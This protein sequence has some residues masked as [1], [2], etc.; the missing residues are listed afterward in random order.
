MSAP[1]VSNTQL[2]SAFYVATFNRAPD[3]SG[4]AFWQAQ[5]PPS[6]STTSAAA[7][8]AAGF[9]ANPVFT[10]NYG[11]DT[12]LQ[13]VNA[14][15]QNVLGGPGDA[16]GVAYW[17]TQLSS[18]QTKTQVLAAF[19]QGALT[20]DLSPTGAFAAALSAGDLAA[21]QA[22]QAFLTNKVNVGLV[23]AQT[24]GTSSNVA[25]TATTAAAIAAD[26]A[27]LASVAILQSVTNDQATAQAAIALI[28]T[29]AGNAAPVAYINTNAPAAVVAGQSFALTVGQD[30]GAAFTGGTGNDVFYAPL[31]SSVIS[32]PQLQT[33]NNSD[34]L[35]GG[36]G[37]NTLNASLNTDLTAPTLKNIQIVNATSEVP[38]SILDLLNATGVTTVAV[39][40][41]TATGGFA[42]VGAATKLSVTQQNSNASFSGST[43]TTINLNLDTVGGKA[44]GPVGHI[45]V[46]LAAGVANV[47]GALAITANN[48]YVNLA[49]TTS[50]A[51]VLSASV[52]AT[53]TNQL[54]F[55]GNDSASIKSLTVTGGGSLDLSASP[56]SAL[57]SV[58]AG[59]GSLKLVSTNAVAGALSITAGAGNDTFTVQGASVKSITTGNGND[60][61]TTTGNGNDAAVLAKQVTVATDQGIVNTDQGLVNAD[62]TIITTQNANI[63]AANTGIASIT[64]VV[65][66]DNATLATDQAT[67]TAATT[68]VTNDQTTVTNDTATRNA[69]QTADTNAINALNT[70]NTNLTNAQ[71]TLATDQATVVA[72]TATKAADQAT[73]NTTAAVVTNLTTM[74]TAIAAAATQAA[75]DLATATAVSQGAITDLQRATINAAFATGLVANA[76]T[77]QADA[78][79]VYTPIVNTANAADA[80]ATTALNNATNAL[81]AANAA[82][83]A[84]NAAIV[85]DNAAVAVATATKNAADTTLANAQTALTVAQTAL[86]NAQTTLTADTLQVTNDQ[87]KLA[88]DQATLTTANANLA[89]ANI[90]K[91]NAQ[92]SLVTDTAALTNAQAILATDQ[93][94]LTAANQAAAVAGALSSTSTTNLGNGNNTL[95]LSNGFAAG[96][97]ITSG[98][99]TTDTIVF[100]QADYSVDSTYTAA[101]LALVSGFEVLGFSDALLGTTYDVS[102]LAGITSV[103]LNSG[104]AAFNFATLSNV[105]DNTVVTLAGDL[106]ANNGALALVTNADTSHNMVN[107]VI[108]PNYFDNNDTNVNQI[109]RFE[110]LNATGFET[111]AINSTGTNTNPAAPVTG[112]KADLV[113]NNLNLTDNSLVTL[114]VTGNQALKVVTQAG[115]THLATINA[116]A[117]TGGL[118]VDAS[119]AQATAAALTVIGSATAANNLTGSHNADTIIGGAGND[120]INGNG[121]G[122]T[123]TGGAGN[124]TFV[125]NNGSSVIGANTFATVTDF[126]ANTV[127][128]G[129]SGAADATGANLAQLNGDVLQ[130]NA[131]G[132]GFSNSILVGVLNTAADATTFLANHSGNNQVIAALDASTGNLYVDNQNTNG[133]ADLYIHLTGVTTLTAAAIHLV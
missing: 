65:A 95:T 108:N 120:T 85:A 48:A 122:D 80:T 82:V 11:S 32:D 121:G 22:R 34:I 71:A 9:A 116:S 50:S 79:A 52:A 104:V 93:A 87:A 97:T 89:A 13:Y 24:L 30:L 60:A 114:T 41:S 59:D 57:T 21:A 47:A 96:A 67:V 101:Q 35:D 132:N 74:T 66:T 133:V 78:L 77:A 83:V 61:V 40:G 2:I 17:V 75:N 109:A 49:E 8:L 76:A 68:A 128:N 92:A 112:Y 129:A 130:I 55:S 124:D 118:I 123:L 27:Y 33:L 12:P 107:V 113:T 44:G 72:D 73:K 39:T 84:D 117:N 1:T 23:Y 18:G 10:A 69:A 88:V 106:V 64:P 111:L 119:A 3:A 36:L 115:M 15:Y 125:F 38:G 91:A 25:A 46:D 6:V 102:K 54:Q 37:V 28:N 131:L 14:L 110:T 26:P 99:G 94:I 51:A 4:L 86:V 29:A 43:A 53:G 105:A 20:A 58:V 126:H 5:V 90:A 42:H 7:T 19:V 81:N 62:N 70:A 31:A 16:S 45:A 56:L 100:K 103:T 63:L 98:T 127:G